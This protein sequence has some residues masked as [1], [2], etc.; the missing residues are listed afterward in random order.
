[1][2]VEELGV[3]C[4]DRFGLL[5]DLFESLVVDRLLPMR[6]GQHDLFGAVTLV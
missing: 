2:G 5:G 4:L 6:G 3:V 1:V